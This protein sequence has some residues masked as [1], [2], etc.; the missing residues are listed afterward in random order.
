VKSGEKSPHI[1]IRRNGRVVI[2][3]CVQSFLHNKVVGTG[4]KL[5]IEGSFLNSIKNICKNRTANVILTGDKL[6][7]L[8]L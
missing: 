5:G 8:P 2:L 6:E 3:E 7:V 1:F 4:G